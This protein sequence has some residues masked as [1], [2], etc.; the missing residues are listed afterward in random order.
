M[1]RARLSLF[2]PCLALL[3]LA[4]GCGDSG[5][6]G[7]LYEESSAGSATNPTTASGTASDTAADSGL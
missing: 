5:S 4:V 1:T 2:A 7:G 6:D 3:T